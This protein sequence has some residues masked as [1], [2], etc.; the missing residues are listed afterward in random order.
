MKVY[1]QNALQTNQLN[2][3][4]AIGALEQLQLEI[5]FSKKD[6]QAH[7]LNQQ[8]E[9]ILDAVVEC[10]RACAAAAQQEY[11]DQAAYER[12]G[13]ARKYG[14]VVC[15]QRT[16]RKK[17]H[18]YIP[19]D[20]KPKTDLQHYLTDCR[21]ES[22]QTDLKQ[23]LDTLEERFSNIQKMQ[24]LA[25]NIRDV[26]IKAA[27]T[28]DHILNHIKLFIDDWVCALEYQPNGPS[29]TRKLKFQSQFKVQLLDLKT[30]MTSQTM[31]GSLLLCENRQGGRFQYAFPYA[32]NDCHLFTKMTAPTEFI[33]QAKRIVEESCRC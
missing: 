23:R 20:R 22:T 33:G 32:V 29:I 14:E 16:R 4:N 21:Y 26:L 8:Q 27:C 6:I 15:S 19:I 24:V 9:D 31:D 10:P 3:D 1:V 17:R 12:S 28:F 18:I 7:T 5:K 11:E 13:R 30:F 2:K 25:K